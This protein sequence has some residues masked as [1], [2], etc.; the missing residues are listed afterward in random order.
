MNFIDSYLLP[1][2]ALDKSYNLYLVILS[3]A[4]AIVASFTAFGVYERAHASTRPLFQTLWIIFGAVSMGIGIWSMHFIGSVALQLPIPVFFDLKI[5]LLSVLPSIL[6]SSVVF[7]LMSQAEFNRTRLL[8]C[9]LLLG[10]SIGAMHYIGMAA[11]ELN[12]SM[13]YLKPIF[14]LSLVVAVILATIALNIKFRAIFKDEYQFITKEQTFSAIVMG[15]A[16]SGMHYT[17][18]FAVEFI[19]L[20]STSF[21]AKGIDAN[22]LFGIVS[23]VLFLVISIALAVPY[24]CRFKQMVQTL[25]KNEEDLKIAATAFQTHEAIMVTNE[26]SEIIRVN[27]AFTRIMGYEEV[28]IVG[29]TPKVLYAGNND[30]FFQ[31]KFWN[32][33]V[34]EGKWN[35]KITSR[36]KSGEVFS[37]W[38]TISAVK[39]EQG[40]TTHYIS[41]FSDIKEFKLAEKEIEKLA[42]YDPLTGLP[43]RRLLHERL[44]HE[45]NLARRYQRAGVLLFLDLDRFKHINDSLGHSV[46]D[47]LLIETARR[48][49]SILRETD[50]AVRIGGDEFIVL[51]SAQDGIHSDLTEQSHVIAEKINKV[52]LEPY[53][54]GGHELYIS[55]SIGITL[56]TG[57]DETVD[58]LLKRADT[59]MYQAKD[60]GRNTYRFYQQSMQE[61]A[62]A[63]L[64]IEKNLRSAI[65]NDEF[66]IY[67]QPQHSDENKIIAVEALMRWNNSNLGII[68]P[69]EFIPI[70]EESGLILKIGQWVI[71]TVCE[72]IISWD[73]LNVAV[74]HIAIN[75]SAKQFHQADFVS[76]LVHTVTDYQIQP[77]RIILEITEVVFIGNIEDAIDKM[78]ALKQKGFRFSIDDFGTGYSSLTYLKRLPFDQLKIDQSFVKEFVNRPADVAIVKAICTMAKGLGL[79]LIAEGV[80]TEEHLA[81]LSGF[82]CHGFQGNY[83]SKPLTTGKL[84]EYLKE[85]NKNG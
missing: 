40:E 33:L 56:Y 67:Y 6:A 63:R 46:G 85:F 65:L 18:M 58:L 78:N 42:F 60:A 23:I 12:A 13:V 30:D 47:E 71:E 68:P 62:D 73:S 24:I 72:Q 31:K 45:L 27:D 55:A 5:T 76:N 3:I 41:F 79:E 2:A 51:G 52:I 14:V 22:F 9:G 43:N 81:F 35:G 64:D 83:F 36:R 69:A 32:T 21:S 4:I 26:R 82:G 84:R 44:A 39:D 10:T 66:K 29:E 37:Q 70:A 75:I 19:P 1:I 57:I 15:I 28:D 20:E 61:A 16:I 77:K 11:M 53:H 17:A 54:I 49:Q 34:N 25:Q 59:A 8:F 7:W 80:E 48:L 50:T 38:Q 74:Q